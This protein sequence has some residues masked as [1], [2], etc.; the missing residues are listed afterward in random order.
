MKTSNTSPYDLRRPR[1]QQRTDG[2]HC[3]L[4]DAPEGFKS[5]CDVL[6]KVDDGSELPAH[7]QILAKYSSV[8]ADM[9]SDGPLCRASHLEKASLPLTD[10]SRATAISLM[11]MLYSGPRQAIHHIREDT[12]MQIASLAHKLNIKV[13]LPC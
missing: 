11:A 2:D 5:C 13:L 1:K 4:D 9:L 8:V 7:S 3:Y 10:C 6:L 12:S